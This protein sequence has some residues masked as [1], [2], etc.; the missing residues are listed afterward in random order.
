MTPHWLH[1]FACLVA[2]ATFLLIVAGASVT[3]NRAGLAVPDWPTTYGQFMY[4]FPISKMVGGILYEHGHR[5]IASAVGLM[6]IV[7]ALWLVRVERRRWLR[8][9][10]IAALAAIIAQGV[11]GGLTVKLLLPPP[12]SIAHAS[13]AEAFFC[14]VI[15]I[16]VLTSRTWTTSIPTETPAAA[17]M[18][19]LSLA[20]AVAIYIQLVLGAVIRHSDAAIIAHIV[21]AVAVTGCVVCLTVFALRH[22][23][24]RTFL[25]HVTA[26]SSLVA[27]QIGLGLA[28]LL[29]RVP[30]DAVGQL[31]TMQVAL[32]TIHLALGALILAVSFALT[33]RAYWFLRPTAGAHN[34]APLQAFV[35]LTKPRIMLMVLV[36]TALGF[37]LGGGRTT[38]SWSALALTLLGVGCASGGAAALNNYLDRHVD[39]RMVRTRNRALP[40][41][42]IEPAQ[43]L[44]FGVSLVLI[45][46]LALAWWVNLLTGFL[47]LLAAFLYVLVYTPMKRL[48]W[49][50]TTIGAIPGAIPPLCG[51]AA[52]S[53]KLEVQAWVLFAILFVWQHPHF[54][55]IAW[56]F[57][58][59]Y[60]N[61]G[62][63]MLTVV[64]PSG[65]STARQ[66]LAFSV[67][68]IGVSLLPSV[69]GM[70]GRLYLWGAL[71]L[72][73]A[74]LVV[75]VLFCRARTFAGA[76]RLLKASVVYLP[77]LVV[78]MISDRL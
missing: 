34:P 11:L 30:K 45:G 39:A 73:V 54:Y 72:S 49:F 51:W 42:V 20:T 63:Q 23:P 9:L 26:L 18:Q 38:R 6:T 52:A 47:V 60:R 67:A 15:T 50:N 24:Q 55:S 69:V 58:D 62:L 1:R 28:T 76:R 16:A 25:A 22:I 10:G 3:S 44:A 31:S 27:V 35:E 17:G 33:L 2:A 5:L 56:M 53:G 71:T 65:A 21:G 70:T 74:L 78:L 41:G 7:L 68:L 36:T 48:S 75:G 77:L 4:S 66:T 32:P 59:D 37:F 43:A 64:D 57:K 61:A 40:A 13:L 46:S 14:V 12:I 8:R 29:V 19:R